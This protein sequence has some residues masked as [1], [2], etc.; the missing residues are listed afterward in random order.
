MFARG[1]AQADTQGRCDGA[2]SVTDRQSE[3]PRASSGVLLL[4]GLL[5]RYQGGEALELR[6][7]VYKR[8]VRRAAFAGRSFLSV[9]HFGDQLVALEILI[10]FC[11]GGEGRWKKSLIH[12][13]LAG[14]LLGRAPDLGA[15]LR[16]AV[17]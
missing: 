5:D 1:R 10:A 15:A 14:L 13:L 6:P 17:V 16:T 2:G 4:W 3:D 11:K 8:D 7:W 9:S 12:L